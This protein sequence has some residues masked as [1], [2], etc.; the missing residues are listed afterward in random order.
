[1][2]TAY[3]FLEKVM[4]LNQ[5][6]IKNRKGHAGMGQSNNVLQR[7]KCKKYPV[8]MRQRR[9]LMAQK[10]SVTGR[11]MEFVKQPVGMFLADWVIKRKKELALM[12]K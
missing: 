1:M 11:T 4:V 8:A 7:I 5:A 2:K 10:K 6:E 9:Y 3:I 12:E